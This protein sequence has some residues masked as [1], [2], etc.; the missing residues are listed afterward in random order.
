MFAFTE[1]E[2]QSSKHLLSCV[3][4]YFTALL[5]QLQRQEKKSSTK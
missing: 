1:N 3:L 4:E 5:L 2:K